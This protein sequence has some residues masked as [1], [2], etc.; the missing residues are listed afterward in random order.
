M[1]AFPG[2]RGLRRGA[3]AAWVEPELTT[4]EGEV[5]EGFEKVEQHGFGIASGYLAIYENEDV[6]AGIFGTEETVEEDPEVLAALW[7][8]AEMDGEMFRG[9]CNGWGESAWSELHPEWTAGT[10]FQET[11]GEYLIRAEQA[12]EV[13]ELDDEMTLCIRDA[14]RKSKRSRIPSN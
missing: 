5:A 10:E 13:V 9:G 1:Y 4:P 14:G 2:F 3:C 6:P 7:S 8:R 11:L 12:P